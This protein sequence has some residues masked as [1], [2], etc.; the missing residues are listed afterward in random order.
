MLGI[1]SN[2]KMCVYNVKQKSKCG[3]LSLDYD[4][5][6]YKIKQFNKLLW[7]FSHGKI[8][9]N[10][11]YYLEYGVIIT[12]NDEAPKSEQTLLDLIKFQKQ[13]KKPVLDDFSN[14]DLF[15]YYQTGT[16]EKTTS[17]LIFFKIKD[18]LVKC[19]PPLGLIYK[20][21]LSIRK[22]LEKYDINNLPSFDDQ[23]VPKNV[24]QD[25][26]FLNEDNLKKD[27]KKQKTGKFENK[28]SLRTP[29]ARVKEGNENDESEHDGDKTVNNFKLMEDI[30]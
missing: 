11:S 4:S 14:G 27:L 29:L 1:D 25:S 7:L 12:E 24:N 8:N 23:K 26:F 6:K 30:M 9:I 21:G 3:R 10:L 18:I 19:Y 2:Q 16:V 22:I 5:C 20:K 28:K 17:N 13:P 15:N